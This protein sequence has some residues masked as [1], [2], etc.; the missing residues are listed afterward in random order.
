MNISWLSN[1]PWSFT[2]YGNQT[3]LFIPRIKELGHEV[4]IQAFYGH[5]GSPINWQGIPIYGKGFH[6][7]G[8]DIMAAHARNFKADILISLMD[9]W[10]MQPELLQNIKWVPWFPIDHE[11]LPERMGKPARAAYK[12]I[13]FSKFGERMMQD[14]GIDCY[15]VPHGVDT[16]NFIPIDRKEARERMK[17]P[18]DAFI[19][20]MVAANKGNPPRKAFFE[21][22]AAFSYLKK[23]H[24]DAVLYLHTFD[25][26]SGGYETVNLVEFCSYQGLVVGKDVI[27]ADQYTYML[28]YPDK[29]MNDLYNA[30]DVHLLVSNGEGFGIPIL[31]AQASGCPVIV[32]DWT[33][34]P[35]LCFSGW[36]VDRKD[37]HPI[38]TNLASYQFVGHVGAIADHL[39]SAYRQKDNE[40]RRRNAR[41]GALAYDADVVIE[42][43]WK[44]VL[45]DIEKSIKEEKEEQA[46]NLKNVKALKKARHVHQWS[47]IGLYVNGVAHRPCVG[48]YDS[49]SQGGIVED[50]FDVGLGLD[51][52]NDTDGINKIVGYEIKHDYKLD[53]LA[54]EGT[55][56]DIG[57]HKGLVSCYIAKQ[58]PN[59]KVLAYEPVKENFAALLENIKR[60]G[61]TNIKAHN[62][63]VTEDGRKVNIFTDPIGNSGG[64]TLYGDGNSQE[65]ESVTLAQIFKS[66]KIDRLALLK[67]DCEGA[68]FEILPPA[69]L[70]K[71]DRLRGEFHKGNGDVDALIRDVKANIPD[72]VITVQG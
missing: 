35:E 18:Q 48:C 29:A 55:V 4:A 24:P 1:A 63:A 60:N 70:S 19:V 16:K 30:F 32:G 68:E 23:K 20:G 67:I 47:N 72:V 21:N 33:S 9:I 7:Y 71:I 27:F 52:V 36:K 61:L 8:Q 59:V 40:A 43:Y 3:K 53:G 50:F 5:D 46:Q 12:R 34:M 11:P 14:A 41:S 10:V 49:Q 28:G 57:A 44:P 69:P 31:E 42:R 38:W 51:L 58:Y 6:P 22:I 45:E 56:I 17:L 25:G 13:V 15:Y 37:A 26:S 2:G 66:N 65:V 64:S 39:E 62:K 54:L